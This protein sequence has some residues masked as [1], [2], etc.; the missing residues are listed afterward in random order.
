MAEHD[1]FKNKQLIFDR[2]LSFPLLI[3][4]AETNLFPVREVQIAQYELA[5]KANAFDYAIVTYISFRR[6]TPIMEVPAVLRP[7]FLPVPLPGSRPSSPNYPSCHPPA[8]YPSL[9]TRFCICLFIFFTFQSSRLFLELI[10]I[11]YG[12]PSTKSRPSINLA[13]SNSPTA[14][15]PVSPTT[16]TTSAFFSPTLSST[17]PAH[18]ERLASDILTAE[19]GLD[20]RLP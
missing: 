19:L 14:T 1:L 12:L 7:L 6:F 5:Q 16:P 18:R 8:V 11:L 9:P 15:K 17:P 13:N 10:N 20:P 3:H 4:L 2:R